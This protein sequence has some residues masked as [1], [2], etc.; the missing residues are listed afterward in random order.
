MADDPAR[1]SPRWST[2]STCRCRIRAVDRVLLVHALEMAHDP[3]ALLREV[4]RVLAAGGRLLA[5][6]P[7]RRGL[8]ARMDTTPFGH[9]RPYSRTQINAA[10]AR[11]L[12]HADRMERGA[13]CAADRARLVPAFGGGLGAHR[14]DDLGAVRGRAHRGGNQAGLSR[15]SR[16]GANRPAWCRRSSRRWR[17]RRAALALDA[18]LSGAQLSRA[19]SSSPSPKSRLRRSPAS[20][21]ARRRRDGGAAGGAAGSGRPG[22]RGRSGCRDC[23]ALLRLRAALSCWGCWLLA[24]GDEGRQ[25]VD[26]ACAIV[27]DRAGRL[28]AAGCCCC[29][30]AC[31][32]LLREWLRVARQKGCGS[33]V[34][35][36]DSPSFVIGCWPMSSFVASSS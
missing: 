36:G 21:A 19:E 6:V 14:R 15:R 11:H 13:L 27:A 24:A 2:S 5:V 22:C 28:R 10:P 3:G 31:C 9:G 8:W 17:L 25:P 18:R 26:V 20:R 4:W 7:N 16:R 34:P 35:N 12:V 1:R 33:R 23:C 32:W 30:L 29:G